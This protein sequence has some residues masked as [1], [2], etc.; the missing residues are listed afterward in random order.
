MRILLLLVSL[1]FS[2]FSFSEP[3]FW[4]AKKGNIDLM[5][6]GSV[7]VGNAGMYPLPKPILNHLKESKGLI[8]EIDPTDIQGLSL[9]SPKIRSMQILNEQQRK[10]LINISEDLALPKQHLLNSP[11]WSSAITIQQKQWQLFGYTS[12]FGVDNHFIQSA[13]NNA[14]PLL[15]LETTQFQLGLFTTMKQEGAALLLITLDEYKDGKLPFDCLINSWKRGDDDDLSALLTQSD[16]PED[17]ANS[18]IYNRNKDWSDKLS[19]ANFYSSVQGHIKKT[20][21]TAQPDKYTM[22]VGALHLVGKDNVLQLLTE[23]GFTVL[24]R[25]TKTIGQTSLTLQC[26]TLISS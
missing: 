23:K 17:I 15:P 14:V 22:V 5:I 10:E 19:D 4:S 26:E 1:L 24:K 7:H 13:L 18:L 25:S 11:P 3:S 12:E 9:P 20:K 16:M 2:H 6:I 21:N 8:V